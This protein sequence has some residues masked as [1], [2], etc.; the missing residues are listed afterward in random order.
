MF[1]ITRLLYSYIAYIQLAILTMNTYIH[2]HT[3]LYNLAMWY[4]E[5]NKRSCKHIDNTLT[6]RTKAEVA[7]RIYVF[8]WHAI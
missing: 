6:T 7:I 3:Q 8:K 5:Q 1:F 4:I 2:E